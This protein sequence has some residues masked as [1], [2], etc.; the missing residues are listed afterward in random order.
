[1]DPTQSTDASSI[2]PSDHRSRTLD[3]ATNAIWRGFKFTLR[4]LYETPA[5]AAMFALAAVVMRIFISSLVAPFVGICVS[6]VLTR[7]A[8]KTLDQNYNSPLVHIKKQVYLINKK[9]PNIQ[10]L[11]FISSLVISLLSP[12]AGFLMGLSVGAFGSIVLDVENYKL[13]QQTKRTD[14]S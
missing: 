6:L 8:I 12:T 3:S 9:Y 4:T 7:L 1:M 11:T 5:E 10:F 14:I 13:L 2:Y